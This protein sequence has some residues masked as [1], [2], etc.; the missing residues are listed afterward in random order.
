MSAQHTPGR[1][2]C[3]NHDAVCYGLWHDASHPHAMLGVKKKVDDAAKTEAQAYWDTLS[4][5]ARRQWRRDARI[6]EHP[7]G[8]AG[9]AFDALAK[10]KGE[11]PT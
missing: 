10:A 1:V 11:A 6:W 3:R 9:V 7:E 8:A 4:E 5:D 2:K